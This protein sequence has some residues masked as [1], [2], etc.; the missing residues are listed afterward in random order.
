MI[1]E[2][3]FWLINRPKSRRGKR[4]NNEKD[5]APDRFFEAFERFLTT[6]FLNQTFRLQS[7]NNNMTIYKLST[8]H[9]QTT[10]LMMLKTVY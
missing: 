1:T 3:L 4:Q 5:I 10:T 7:K 2:E 8:S 9:F 6:L